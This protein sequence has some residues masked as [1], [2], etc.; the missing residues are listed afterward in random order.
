MRDKGGL[1]FKIVNRELFS[2]LRRTRGILT[3][4]WR[5]YPRPVTSCL[6]LRPLIQPVESR[7]ET[8]EADADGVKQFRL[9]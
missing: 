8:A 3:D 2:E 6:H 1:D 9:P 7:L 4:P 5:H